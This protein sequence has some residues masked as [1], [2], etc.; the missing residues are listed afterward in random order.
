MGDFR[1]KVGGFNGGWESPIEEALPVPAIEDGVVVLAEDLFEPLDSG[2]E[3]D[4][5]VDQRAERFIERFYQEMKMQR[6]E[7][8]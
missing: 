5:S 8:I 4:E 2:E 1:G 6:Q 7:S 3:D